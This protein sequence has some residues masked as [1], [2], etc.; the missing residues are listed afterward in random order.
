[1]TIQLRLEEDGTAVLDFM[2]D[3]L[4]GTWEPG[5]TKINGGPSGKLV[6]LMER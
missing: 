4:E 6:W 3:T 2:E 5:W 1:M